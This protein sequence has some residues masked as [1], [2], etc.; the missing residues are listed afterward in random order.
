MIDRELGSGGMGTVYL[1]HHN[2]T[3]RAAAVKMLPASLAREPGFK[4]RFLREIEAMQKLKSPH[5]VE[6]YESGVEQGIPFYAM[7]YVAGETLADKILREKRLPWREVI[8]IAVQVARALK[9]A[10]NTGVIHRDLKPSNL[11]LTPDQTVKLT[12]FGIAQVFA[13][14]K[15]TATG[16][17]LGTPE[18]MSPEQSQGKRVTK[19][20]DIYS[21]GAVMYVMLTGRPPFTGKSALD[22]AQKH[23]FSQFDSP[24]RI[25]PEIPFWL[26]EIVCQC[27]AKKPEDRYA[28]AYVLMLR[29]QEVPKK[30]DLR[31]TDSPVPID[32]KFDAETLSATLPGDG[33]ADD[34]VGGTLV[35][36]L[37]QHQLREESRGSVLSRMFDNVWVLVGLL[38]IIAAFTVG[39]AVWNRKDPES[40]FAR[41]EELMSRPE[42]PAWLVA[43]R[44]CFNPLL[45]LNREN[46]EPRISPFLKQIEL[47][48]MKREILGK[49]FGNEKLSSEPEAALRRALR[50]HA[51]GRT[52]ESRLQLEALTA[53][54]AGNEEFAAIHALAEDAWK[55]LG[56]AQD[57][58]RWEFLERSLR[59][60]DELA[61][62]GKMSEARAIW[63]GVI[64]L[65]DADPDAHRFAEMARE[66]LQQSRNSE[67][68]TPTTEGQQ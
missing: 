6:L 27:L 58:S 12:D 49:N 15:L 50:L 42:G 28:D 62:L 9:A 30:V 21:L 54:L 11:L 5:I 53:L 10:H 25:V 65:Y 35:K 23:R 68:S 4:D 56:D 18:Y 64:E 46:W 41:G 36:E 60:G 34:H 44:D 43:K 45:E 7:E 51:E 29:L 47:Y 24:K 1:G 39:M 22:I 14:S 8:E 48:E 2:E 26:D 19:Q 67:S 61:A 31:E 55:K 16:G 38:G 57:P 13:T 17:I 59:R 3:G 40:L 66:R 20:S 33:A 37:F 63:R 52:G 32:A